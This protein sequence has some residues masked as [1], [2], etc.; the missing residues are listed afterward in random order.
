MSKNKAFKNIFTNPLTNKT[1]A[2]NEILRFPQLAKTLEKISENGY[3]EFYSGEISVKLI[4]ENNKMGIF[5]SLKFLKLIRYI[6]F[7]G[8]ILSEQDLKNYKSL[9]RT[10]V[11]FNL[12]KN[13]I[14]TL[15][16]P[17]YIHF[18]RNILFINVHR[19]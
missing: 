18:Y 8:G 3:K 1:Y 11:Q 15:P 13:K 12:K 2:T 5:S 9:N 16:P 19:L 10:P 14:F 4:A 6:S 7:L 17:R